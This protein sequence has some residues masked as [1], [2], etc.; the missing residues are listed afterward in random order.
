[1]AVDGAEWDFFVSYTQADRRWAEWIAWILEEKGFR[2]LIQ[3]WDFVPGSNWLDDMQ[4]GAARSERTLAVLSEA[5][6]GS[7][8]GQAEWLAAWGQDEDGTD[9]KLLPVRVTDCDRPGFLSGVVGIDL[10]GVDEAKAKARLL[11]AVDG[12]VSGRV[13]PVAQPG[14]P[15]QSR[16][17]GRRTPFP[18]ALPTVWKVPSRNFNFVGRTEDLEWLRREVAAE[19]RVV[20]QSIRGMGGVG[21]TQL[22]TEFAHRNAG[23]YELV[24][25]IEAEKV[26][27][28]PDQFARMAD[29]LG[30]EPNADPEKLRAQVHRALQGLTGWLLIFDNADSVEALQPWL[31]TMP[32][33]PGMPGHVIVTTRRSG[34]GALGEVLQ[35]DVL[36]KDAAVALLS[37]RVSGLDRGVAEEIAEAVGCLPLAL[38][39]TA[40]FLDRSQMPAAEYLEILTSRT[41]ATLDKGQ[42]PTRGDTVA[43]VWTLSFERL[44]NENPAAMQLMDICAY[45]A[46]EAIPLNLF[47]EHA[48]LL[49]VP[50]SDAASD[51][52]AFGEA[53]AALADYSLVER[54][55]TNL[56]IHRLVQAALRSRHQ[57]PSAFANPWAA[58]VRLLWADTPGTIIG[59]P[60]NWPRWRQLLPHVLAATG[61][62]DSMA[63]PSGE[64]ATMDAAWLLARAATYLQVHARPSEASP[65]MEHALH[66]AEATHGP[67]HP[68]VATILSLLANILRDLADF[69]G[70][71]PLL[72]RALSIDE[73]NYGPVHTDVATRLGLLA[74]ILRDRGNA[75]EAKP[76]MERALRITE[77]VC[78]PDDSSVAV[79]LSGLAGVLRDL[80]EAD[81][82]RPLMER[83]LVIDEKEFGPNHPSTANAL[84]NLALVLRDLGKVEDAKPLMERALRI[85]ESTYGSDHPEVASG[86]SSLGLILQGLDDAASAKPLMERALEIRENTYWPGHPEVA[87]SLSKLA[88]ILLDLG[89]P[90]G[91]R[92]LMQ[93]ALQILEKIHGPDDDRVTRLRDELARITAEGIADE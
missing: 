52:L 24:W 82:A 39:K 31:P 93:R 50:L 26:A 6:L 20:V 65:L 16:V 84:N 51:P 4:A 40:A 10:F 64:Q 19:S 22:A 81:A 62:V 28:I 21:K 42:R 5:Y 61:F 37:A 47:T 91:A 36:H 67:K 68:D 12:A 46:P 27:T 58:A 53:I 85:K 78:G 70:A 41:E 45:L 13:K 35:V 56:Q 44:L 83:A 38:E 30:M 29:E 73:A 59:E 76:L 54:T 66:L 32:L 80:K 60:Q 69:R 43:T 15:G 88:S 17:R 8:F 23:Q 48:D 74:R 14:F 72:R 77:T 89:D 33:A 90:A 57:S 7:K 86:L 34:F 71:E 92:P 49:P 3:A 87:S 1:M 79:R 25:W 75:V 55:G 18:N 11:A 9:R 2:V 63:G